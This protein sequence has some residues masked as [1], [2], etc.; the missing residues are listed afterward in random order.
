MIFYPAVRA[1]LLTL[2]VTSFALCSNAQPPSVAEL[3]SFG[4]T[5]LIGNE[6]VPIAFSPGLSGPLFLLQPIVDRLGGQLQVGP[7]NESHRLLIA[8]TEVLLGPGAGAMTVGREVI[9][10]SQV[11]VLTENGVRVPLDALKKSYGDL[12]GL[13][14]RWDG[15][16]RQLSVGRQRP[17]EINVEVQVVHIQGIT[18]V[19]LQFD[20]TP[21]YTVNDKGQIVDIE[22]PIDRLQL[23][24]GRPHPSRSLLRSVKVDEH[25][26][27]LQLEPGAAAAEPYVLARSPGATSSRGLRLVLDLS[28]SGTFNTAGTLTDRPPPGQ[29]E[30][31]GGALRTVVLDPGHGGVEQGALGPAGS[32]EK[33]LT[34]ILAK[35]LKR[36]LEERLAV[37]VVLTRN[38]DADLP[39]ATRTALANQNQANLFISLHLNASPDR[40]AHG[41]ETYFLSVD[42]SDERALEIAAA[43]NES[44][45]NEVSE[46]PDEGLQLLLWDLAQSQHLAA[47]QQLGS[48]IQYELSQTLGLTNRGVRQAPFAVLVGATMPAVLLELG[49]ITNPDE[50]AELLDPAYRAQLVDAVVKAVVRFNALLEQDDRQ[51][52]VGRP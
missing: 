35:A 39:L 10:L 31:S 38:D 45:D 52:A 5:L 8:D 48:L 43:E 13:E 37:N 12:L 40:S 25:T 19:V 23:T 24:Q 28:L 30:P 14:L 15:S 1:L 47:S 51:A 29:G 22:I 44:G 26:I 6:Q 20:Q 36:K 50:E 16:L 18:T 33:A 17:R 34:L 2:A 9:V 3:P 21:S 11:P 46:A 42:A 7:L 41:A 4:A 49:F 32:E 27:R